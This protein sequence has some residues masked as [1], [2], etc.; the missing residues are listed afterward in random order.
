MKTKIKKSYFIPSLYLL[1]LFMITIGVYLTKKQYDNYEEKIVDDNITYVSN[2]IFSRTVPI[3]NI[4]EIIN[5]PYSDESVKIVRY[6]YNS[7]D[8]VTKKEKSVVYYEDT[9]MPN[10][11]V[12]YISDNTFD[13]LNIYDG[14]VVDVLDN[15]LLGKTV[16][17]RHNGELISVYQGLGEV[18]VKKGDIV[19]SGQKIGTSGTNKINKDLGNHLHFEIYKNGKTIDPLS[20][21]NK[22]IGDI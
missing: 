8:D 2:S 22:K 18:E 10:T 7:S 5:A 3:V 1:A 12:D 11:G 9:Y 6:F 13:I 17:I 14:T 19:F 15:E 16:Q 4:P 21:I 20:C